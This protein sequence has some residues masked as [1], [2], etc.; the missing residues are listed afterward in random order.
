MKLPAL[1]ASAASALLLLAAAANAATNPPIR[2]A[3]EG[4][5]YMCGGASQQELAFMDMVSPRWAATL[6]FAVA[7]GRRG[8]FSEPVQVKVRNKYN[9]DHV[10]SAQAHGPLMLARLAPGT[11]DVEATI[12]PLTLQQ[13]LTIGLGAPGRALFVWPS[14]FDMA[15]ATLPRQALAQGTAKGD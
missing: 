13:T 11:Y 2:M 7:R 12:G 8:E 3:P 10:L 15:S 9:G 6:E 5:E 4:V 14:N 1:V